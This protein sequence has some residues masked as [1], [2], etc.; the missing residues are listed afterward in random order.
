MLIR[1]FTNCPLKYKQD[2][3][4]VIIVE[5]KTSMNTCNVGSIKLPKVENATLTDKVFDCGQSPRKLLKELL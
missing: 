4:K 5:D 1:V 3:H 2:V